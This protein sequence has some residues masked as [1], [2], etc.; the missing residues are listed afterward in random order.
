MDLKLFMNN[1]EKIASS[2]KIIAM[3]SLLLTNDYKTKIVFIAY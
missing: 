3:L 1:N 2:K